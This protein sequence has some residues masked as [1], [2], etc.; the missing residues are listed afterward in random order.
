MSPLMSSG[1]YSIPSPPLR[2]IHRRDRLAVSTLFLCGLRR[3]EVCNLYVGD[4]DLIDACVHVR[5]GKGGNDRYVPLLAPVATEF[6]AYVYVRPPWPTAA[7]VSGGVQW[8]V[9]MAC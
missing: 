5:H 3:Q 6:V 8:A 7:C 4:Y 1:A 2:W 9:P